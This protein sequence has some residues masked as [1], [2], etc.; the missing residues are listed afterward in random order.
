MPG[1]PAPDIYLITANKL[2]LE[3]KDCMVIEDSKS[4]LASATSAGIGAVVAL[5]PKDT[6]ENLKTY[7]KV[8]QTIERLDELMSIFS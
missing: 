4:G 5:G 6:H 1:K 2:G 3:P 7:G 8:S